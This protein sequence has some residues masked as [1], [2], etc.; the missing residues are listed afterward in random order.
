MVHHY[1]PESKNRVWSEKILVHQDSIFSGKGDAKGPILEEYLE[2]VFMINYARYSALL[3]NNL[4]PQF[5]LNT[6]VY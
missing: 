5:A 2:K 4:K 6:K 1:E 3:L